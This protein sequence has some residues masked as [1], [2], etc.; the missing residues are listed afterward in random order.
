MDRRGC[1]IASGLAGFTFLKAT[2]S[3]WE[4]YL[5][6]PCTTIPETH[7]RILS[8][9]LDASWRWARDPADFEAAN[10]LIR[11][12][13]MGVFA[14][15]YSFSAQDSLYRMGTAALEAVPE[16]ETITLAAPNKH[17]LPVNLKPFGLDN[18]NRVFTPTDEPHGQIECTIGR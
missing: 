18:P 1:R 17:Y 8:T 5:K 16:L 15:T 7:D 4:N 3:G 2:E 6:D 10:T 13:M 9:S 12:T 11:E 14:T